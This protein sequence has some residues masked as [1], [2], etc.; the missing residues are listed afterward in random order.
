MAELVYAVITAGLWGLILVYGAV[1]ILIVVCLRVMG[2]RSLW[3]VVVTVVALAL[4]AAF[5]QAL[6]VLGVS[7]GPVIEPWLALALGRGVVL[8]LAGGMAVEWSLLR[9]ARPS[10]LGALV[11]LVVLQ[12]L[13]SAWLVDIFVVEPHDVRGTRLAFHYPDLPAD[14]PPLRI[15]HLTDTHVARW[16]RREAAVVEQVNAFQPDLI[17]F[18]GDYLNLS[19]LGDETARRDFRRLVSQLRAPLGMYATEGSVDARDLPTLFDGLPVEVLDSEVR[20]LDWGGTPV[21][22]VGVACWHD[23]AVDVPN[24]DRTLAAVPSDGGLR[25]LLYHS[26]ELVEA[27]RGRGLHLFL[28]GHTHGGQFRLPFLGPVFSI[29]MYDPRYASGVFPLGGEE[30]GWMIVSRGLGMEGWMVPRVRW[31]CPPEVGLL[32]VEPDIPGDL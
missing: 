16:T 19:Y 8:L 25:I 30:Q 9:N 18:T 24:L 4:D 27:A 17:L 7:F 31:L 14:F 21:H 20:T 10:L 15:A 2:R 6:P 26:P 1:A 3:L 22:L 5:L 32:T 11:L 12:V 28:A 29:P 23:P 13:L